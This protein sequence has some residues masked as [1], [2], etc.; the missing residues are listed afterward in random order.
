MFAEVLLAVIWL[1]VYARIPNRGC[2]EAAP[3]RNACVDQSEF[4]QIN[5][6]TLEIVGASTRDAFAISTDL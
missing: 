4:K 3:N 6:Q 1:T 5:T 2:I